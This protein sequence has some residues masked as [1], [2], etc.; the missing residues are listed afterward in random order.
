MP[1]YCNPE[2]AK[3]Q[4]PQDIVWGDTPESFYLVR[5]G[6]V[7]RTGTRV[8]GSPGKDPHVPLGIIVTIDAEPM[9]AFD[10]RY[11]EGRIISTLTSGRR[12]IG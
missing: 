6:A 11:I 8:V 2:N 12:R 4:V 5:K 9:D 7:E 10:R 3:E 1:D